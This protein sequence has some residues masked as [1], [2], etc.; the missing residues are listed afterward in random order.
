MN[1]NITQTHSD[2]HSPT[3]NDSLSSGGI[4]KTDQITTSVH[5]Q[6]TRSQIIRFPVPRI[7]GLPTIDI[8]SQLISDSSIVRPCELVAGLIHQGTKAVLA[9]G[10]K[11]GKTWVLLDLALS[12]ATGRQ[13]LRWNTMQGKVLFI[14]F[15]IKREFI[16]ERIAVLMNRRQITDIE[17]LDFWNLRG[18]TSD[19]EAL[20]M[21]IIRQVEGKNYS[22]IILDPI[23]KA[24]IGKSESASSGVGMLCSQI[25][26]IAE[27]S[28]AA[29]VYAHHFTKGNQKKKSAID[30]MSGSGV[31]ARDADTIITLTEHNE[32]NCY[33]VE[34]IL[35]NLMHQPAFV[36]EWQYPVM[37][38]REDL[39]PEDVVSEEPETIDTDQGV[40]ELLK[41]KPL[42]SGDWQRQALELG[43]PRA[44]FY[45]IKKVFLGNDDI[46][47]NEQTK[48]WSLRGG[49][50]AVSNEKNADVNGG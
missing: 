9:S 29:I 27:R 31:F 35:R 11:A 39:D 8:G 28:G 34:M 5:G 44:T 14:N 20:V 41:D 15:E 7:P 26:R 13:F 12:V 18:K 22:M 1:T 19:F 16:K 37:V 10:S 30:R 45:R 6:L 47:F 50:E 48:L 4:V 24:M 25:E 49:S 3:L 46:Q 17:N 40:L 32:P 23:Y 38:E 2:P 42:R 43:V 33:T 21:N 36:V